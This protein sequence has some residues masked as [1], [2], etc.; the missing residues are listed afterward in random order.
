V[1]LFSSAFFV[2]GVFPNI[3]LP[4]LRLGCAPSTDLALSWLP[5]PHPARALSL[6]LSLFQLPFPSSRIWA[7]LLGPLILENSTPS[8]ITGNF[9][10]PRVPPITTDHQPILAQGPLLMSPPHTEP[11]SLSHFLEILVLGLGSLS[12][13]GTG[14]PRT[15]DPWWWRHP[16]QE[17][18]LYSLLRNWYLGDA[19]HILSLVQAS[20]WRLDHPKFLQT[21]HWDVSWPTLG[22]F[23]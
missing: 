5:P 6:S 11:W 3:L 15:V 14:Y 16:S 7:A 17:V 13:L 9:L 1:R 23:T 4:W 21:P 18:H 8:L 2:S 20:L 10:C 22:L 12:S 19:H